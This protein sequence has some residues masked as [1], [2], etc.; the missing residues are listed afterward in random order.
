MKVLI[1]APIL[2][3]HLLP[4]KQDDIYEVEERTNS[5]FVATSELGS[6]FD[7][8]KS[9]CEVLLP[10]SEIV[11]AHEEG[12]KIE[13]WASVQNSGTQWIEYFGESFSTRRYYRIAPE[14]KVKY[15]EFT[16]DDFEELADKW[17]HGRYGKF[18]II[19]VAAAGV[20]I[21]SFGTI[22]FK[23]LLGKYN[24]LETQKPAGKEVIE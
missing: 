4:Y 19:G 22:S 7:I 10:L 24:F 3:Q 8:I 11:K 2:P 14:P 12:K 16:A 1:T 5:V 21:G 23:D 9:H 17:I 15:I 20:V 18:K 13:V 6:S